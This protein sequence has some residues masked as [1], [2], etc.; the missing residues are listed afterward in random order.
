MGNDISRNSDDIP[1][2]ELTSSTVNYLSNY[3]VLPEYPSDKTT[4]DKLISTI[5]TKALKSVNTDFRISLNYDSKRKF[6][7]YSSNT[8]STNSPDSKRRSPRKVTSSAISMSP[9][10]TKSSNTKLN[11]TCMVSS[12]LSYRVMLPNDL[13]RLEEGGHVVLVVDKDSYGF[14]KYIFGYLD[15]ITLSIHEREQEGS[16]P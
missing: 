6:Q 2:H 15:D 3:H 11:N 10:M 16:A 1:V 4:A 9:D 14:S 13:L 7:S 5:A 12:S 8:N